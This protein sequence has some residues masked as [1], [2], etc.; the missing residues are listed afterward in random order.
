MAEPGINIP[1]DGYGAE[2]ERLAS[3]GSRWQRPVLRSTIDLN[4]YIDACHARGLKVVGIVAR[5]SLGGAVLTPKWSISDWLQSLVAPKSSLP[6]I[7]TSP[8]TMEFRDAAQFY[9][10]RYAG[11][12]DLLQIGNESDHISPSSWSMD[13]DELNELLYQFNVWFP[14]ET[15]IVGP[16]LVSGDATWVRGIDQSLIDLCAVHGYGQRPWG[17]P[18]DWPW[19]P[20]NF[21]RI[22]DLLQRYADELEPGINLAATEIGLSTTEVTHEQQAEYTEEIM[23]AFIT[24]KAN[25]RPG[26]HKAPIL[27]LA[28][29]FS[30]GD[31]MVPEF[32][33]FDAAGNPKPAAAAYTRVAG[34]VPPP[35]PKPPDPPKPPEPPMPEP[36]T[37]PEQSYRAWWTAL[38]PNAEYN[39]GNGFETYWRSHMG[40]LG[41][42]LD[43]HEFSDGG[44]QWRT[45]QSG[46]LRW[47]S[48]KG[49]ELVLKP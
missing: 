48:D 11:K 19:L 2:P 21:G 27:E 47:S 31:W 16:G 35:E 36:V 26:G 32:G 20:G 38:R 18:S 37:I 34:P 5:E 33:I 3:L 22:G 23:R 12:L 46:A 9:A 42:T 6:E 40:E 30:L 8:L 7:E 44:Y 1:G 4:P 29:L 41:P 49:V 13:H 43:D 14:E 45:F 10:N 39:P 17:E 28:C 25:P 15:L 24:W